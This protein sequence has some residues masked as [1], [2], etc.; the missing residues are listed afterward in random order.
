MATLTAAQKLAAKKREIE[1]RRVLKLQQ[2]QGTSL[3][4]KPKPT[5]AVT[6][7]EAPTQIAAPQTTTT[8]TGGT[9]WALTTTA[10]GGKVCVKDPN[11]QFASSSE[12]RAAIPGQVQGTG[13]AEVTV[14]GE[15]MQRAEQ[16]G[17]A[18]FDRDESGN[19]VLVGNVQNLSPEARRLYDQEQNDRIISDAEEDQRIEDEKEVE[20]QRKDLEEQLERSTA[21]L[22][23]DQRIAADV[24]ASQV[25]G[26]QSAVSAEPGTFESSA[27]RAAGIG[28]LEGITL[29]SKQMQRQ[30]DQTASNIESATRR[31]NKAR[32]DGDRVAAKSA[33]AAL[34]AANR[35][36]E[37]LRAESKELGKEESSKT[38]DF[39]DKM[40][41]NDRVNFL[42]N[43]SLE[44][45]AKLQEDFD[46]ADRPASFLGGLINNAKEQALVIEE[47]K[48][49]PDDQDLNNKLNVLRGNFDKIK[50]EASGKQFEGTTDIKN[51]NFL[52]RLQKDPEKN[53][54]LIADF[55]K[56]TGL[57]EDEEFDFGSVSGGS[58]DFAKARAN[59]PAQGYRTDRHNNPTAFTTDIAKQA[60][61]VEGVDYTVGDAFPNN[62]NFHTARLIGDPV[63]KTIDVIDNIG[64]YTA[65]GQPRWNHTAMSTSQW[66]SMTD[67][68]KNATVKNMYRNEGGNG[69]LVGGV[70]D[71]VSKIQLPQPIQDAVDNADKISTLTSTLEGLGAEKGSKAHRV[72]TA[73]F[74]RK[75]SEE[76]LDPELERRINDLAPLH[77]LWQGGKTSDKD[78]ERIEKDIILNK[79]KSDTEILLGNLGEE[80]SKF[81][82][83][84]ID[85]YN[86]ASTLDDFN[87]KK[88]ITFPLKN[89]DAVQAI[90]NVENELIKNVGGGG[91]L[92]AKV[93]LPIE[94]SR[95]GNEVLELL[96]KIPEDMLGVFDAGLANLAALAPQEIR[97]LLP[98]ANAVD[99]D[100]FIRLRSKITSLIA[101]YRL[102]NLGSAVTP[103]EEAFLRPLLPEITDQPGTLRAKVEEFK[104]NILQAH[105]AT[106]ETVNLPRVTEE[107]LL[108]KKLRIALYQK[109]K[110]D[111]GADPQ[112]VTDDSNDENTYNNTPDVEQS[113]IDFYNSLGEDS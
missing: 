111:T 92:D 99:I 43:L 103:T 37:E 11:G 67:A 48:K 74:L 62:D 57:D 36:A 33:A 21:K 66:Q 79:D 54:A 65:S 97:D 14:G 19:R 90:V 98:D 23:E 108:D 70:S 3:L 91:A 9:R 10:S 49:N 101:P 29:R 112:F 78:M 94:T 26:V 109:Q 93:A 63:Q 2:S 18:T 27:N 42:S 86:K 40:T 16:A 50:S 75:Q 30:F 6:P 69:S 88:N 102:E 47:L 28:Q 64:F 46:A 31:L 22:R 61:L 72:A 107:E 85:L 68:Q 76:V 53:A 44:G 12:C 83:V 38:L 17:D 52:E 39:F 80:G 104:S 13:A 60:G 20:A 59:Q 71:A 25:S 24:S 89:G 15:V 77:P 1:A 58:G 7:P 96:D 4:D 82:D 35:S 81:K 32:A 105:N 41:E 45:Q 100:N 73:A 110:K 56:L 113:D 55:R 84:A 34:N 5:Q 106:R 95:K 87:N 51:L 8:K